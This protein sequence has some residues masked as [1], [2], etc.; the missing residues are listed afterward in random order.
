MVIV[1]HLYFVLSDYKQINDCFGYYAVYK[2]EIIV[3]R[4]FYLEATMN[5]TQI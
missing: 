2:N 5:F 1:F 3:L 4:L